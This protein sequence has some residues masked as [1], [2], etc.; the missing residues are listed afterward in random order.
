[1][2]APGPAVSKDAAESEETAIDDD[3]DQVIHAT[4]ATADD[5]DEHYYHIDTQR[6]ETSPASSCEDLS[7]DATQAQVRSAVLVPWCEEWM[8]FVETKLLLCMQP[9]MIVQ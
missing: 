9:Q 3:L 4:E 5:D 2:A 7:Q 6:E 8:I 1:M